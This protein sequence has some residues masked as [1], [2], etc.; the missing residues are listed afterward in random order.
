MDPIHTVLAL[1]LGVAV[2]VTLARKVGIAYPIVLVL[3]GL[4]LGFVPGLPRVELHP[5]V[6]FLWF[7][8]PLV[9][10]AATTTALREFRFNL[11][12]ITFLSIILVLGTIVLVAGAAHAAIAGMTWATAF[13]LGAIVAAT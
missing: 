10:L 7:L 3:G 4:A 12:P 9:Y 13:V 2:L 8:P 11:R 1:L 5:V 6:P